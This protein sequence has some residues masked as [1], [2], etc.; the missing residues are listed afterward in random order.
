VEVCG[1]VPAFE[2]MFVS[3]FH[4]YNFFVS[5]E[6]FVIAHVKKLGMGSNGEEWLGSGG[7]KQ[8]GKGRNRF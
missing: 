4:S 5:L 8:Q 7:D 6:E 2:F 1:D 3:S